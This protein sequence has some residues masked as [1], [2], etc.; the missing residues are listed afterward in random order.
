[1][2]KKKNIL[3]LEISNMRTKFVKK[4]LQMIHRYA[5]YANNNIF[6]APNAIS[7]YSAIPS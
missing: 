6:N 3:I 7:E 2:K 4:N 5:C 1:M